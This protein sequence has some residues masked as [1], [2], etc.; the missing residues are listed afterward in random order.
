MT[1]ITRAAAEGIRHGDARVIALR[2]AELTNLLARG[3][4]FVAELRA[5]QSADRQD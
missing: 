3:R 1:G 2:D 5:S 4:P